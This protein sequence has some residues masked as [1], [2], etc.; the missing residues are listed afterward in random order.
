MTFIKQQISSEVLRLSSPKHI[1]FFFHNHSRTSRTPISQ[2][3]ESICLASKPLSKTRS[4][5]WKPGTHS[6]PV[7][8]EVTNNNRHRGRLK[9]S[10][11]RPDHF[12]DFPENNKSLKSNFTSKLDVSIETSFTTFHTSKSIQHRDIKITI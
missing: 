3:T 2:R 7:S 12:H 8:Q 11:H 10:H 1:T 6:Y 5:I 9:T 4:T